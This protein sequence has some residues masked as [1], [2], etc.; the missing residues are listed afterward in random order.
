MMV[1]PLLFRESEQGYRIGFR[2]MRSIS[3]LPLFC[4]HLTFVYIWVYPHK[5]RMM[6]LFIVV[7][8]YIFQSQIIN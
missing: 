8:L 1:F 3:W 6:R 4:Q 7:V 2:F 5:M